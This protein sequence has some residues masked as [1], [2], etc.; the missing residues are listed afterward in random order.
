MSK[1]RIFISHS[2][3]D[4]ALAEA[5]VDLIRSA[6]NM[7]PQE[8]RCTSADGHRLPVGA[9]PNKQLQREVLAADA[10]VA[11]ISP[12]SMASSYVLFELGARWGKGGETLFPVLAPGSSPEA[13]KG[14]LP[15]SSALACES[16]GQ[17]LQLVGN[18]AATLGLQPNPAESFQRK[19]EIIQKVRSADPRQRKS[20][21]VG[22]E[23]VIP[24]FMHLD[25]ILF[26]EV[27]ERVSDIMLDD[28]HVIPTKFLFAH[29]DS[30]Q[31]YG[32]LE[33]YSGYSFSEKS[34]ILD[35]SEAIARYL[36]EHVAP[37]RKLTVVSLGIGLGDKDLILLEKL[38]RLRLEVSFTAIDINPAFIQVVMADIRKLGMGQVAQGEYLRCQFVVGDFDEIER[39]GPL[40]PADSP[41]L[42]MALGGTFGNQNE[43]KFLQRLKRV[44]KAPAYL[45]MDF[46]TRESFRSNDKA[47][48]ESEHNKQFISKMIEAFCGEVVAPANIEAV[49]DNKLDNYRGPIS[50]VPN[51]K[52][53]VM[54]GKTVAGERRR[55]GYSTGYH[56]LAL[57][58]FLARESWAV[59]MDFK[60]KNKFLFLCRLKQ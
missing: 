7:P 23:S 4:S 13:L 15:E 24:G 12:A 8:I 44:S 47:G 22:S 38:R 20:G 17:M 54:V 50:E 29:A 11:I 2:S 48:Y 35:N 41:I 45:L 51:A 60:V 9:H 36:I 33:K 19:I 58:N 37:N 39:F 1:V 32:N 34:L 18:L 46:Q 30:Y 43:R 42:F 14:F 10:V 26:H 21:F 56:K 16:Q 27:G 55:F 52:T 28:E 53:L 49:Y 57:I 31:H 6:L 25:S 59:E 5:I 3:R 40:L